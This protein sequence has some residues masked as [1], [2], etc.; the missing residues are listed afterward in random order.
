MLENKYLRKVQYTREISLPESWRYSKPVIMK[1]GPSYIRLQNLVIAKTLR[2]DS[3]RLEI[4]GFPF[5]FPSLILKHYDDYYYFDVG[6][7][8]LLV[9]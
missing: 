5:T 1:C 8:T 3:Q 7:K 6:N 4:S 9:G 2:R